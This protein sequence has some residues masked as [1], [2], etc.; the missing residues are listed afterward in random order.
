[1]REIFLRA[2]VIDTVLSLC[3]LLCFSLSIS[4]SL[5]SPLPPPVP[6]SLILCQHCLHCISPQK[7][8]WKREANPLW[9]GV[10]LFS[11]AFLQFGPLGSVV[12]WWS[13]GTGRSVPLSL[14]KR[15]ENKWGERKWIW[16]KKNKVKVVWKRDKNTRKNERHWEGI[17]VFKILWKTQ[18]YLDCVCVVFVQSSSYFKWGVL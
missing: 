6:A 11:L 8:K 13:S 12:Y 1:M 18:I 9:I 4:P 17:G 7:T 2:F 10:A 3:Q 14:S 5:P 15:F 16:Q